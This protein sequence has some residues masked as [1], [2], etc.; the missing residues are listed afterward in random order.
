MKILFEVAFYTVNIDAK[1]CNSSQTMQ[2]PRHL[3][4]TLLTTLDTGNHLPVNI[5]SFHIFQ[6]QK[7]EEESLTPH[8]SLDQLELHLY[9]GEL[10]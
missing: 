6:L 1:A 5:Y 2:F 8:E 4:V 3:L 9:F 10:D 7:V